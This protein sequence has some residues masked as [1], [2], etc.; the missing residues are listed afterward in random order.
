VQ[1]EAIL[2]MI[3]FSVAPTVKLAVFSTGAP[4]LNEPTVTFEEA[5]MD[6]TVIAPEEL[7]VAPVKVRDPAVTVPVV[8]MEPPLTAPVR[9][10]LVPVKAPPLVMPP[11]QVIDP[12]VKTRFPL[13]T[14][15][16]AVVVTAPVMANV[17]AV[18]AIAGVITE[19]VALADP[20]T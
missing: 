11:E 15:M 20:T 3:Q 7:I 13:L 5:A 14:V 9:V 19:V 10:K 16:P 8:E 2:T 12:A 6:D 1:V 17:P 18:A 4:R